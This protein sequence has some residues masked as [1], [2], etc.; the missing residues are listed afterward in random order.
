VGMRSSSGGMVYWW[1]ELSKKSNWMGI[2]KAGSGRKNEVS[3]IE[4]GWAWNGKKGV[5]S[6][7]CVS[8]VGII[9]KGI[10]FGGFEGCGDCIERKRSA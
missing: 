9:L 4:S 3:F 2:E 8:H 6:S 7:A 10:A 5:Y 1:D